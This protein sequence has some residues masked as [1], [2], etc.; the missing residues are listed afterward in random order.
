MPCIRRR[1]CAPCTH[2]AKNFLYRGLIQSRV[3]VCIIN[4]QRHTRKIVLQ[5]LTIGICMVRAI[6]LWLE[7]CNHTKFDGYTTVT[8]NANFFIIFF[9]F[10]RRH[11]SRKSRSSFLVSYLGIQDCLSIY[12]LPA[13]PLTADTLPAAARYG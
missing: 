1:P 13:L 8:K 5:P 11:H 6:F 3:Y 7:S 10:F 9:N 12:L 2:L 4:L